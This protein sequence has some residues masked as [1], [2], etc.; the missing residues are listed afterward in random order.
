MRNGSRYL[1]SEAIEISKGSSASLG[2]EA[3]AHFVGSQGTE[4][5]LMAAI[6]IGILVGEFRAAVICALCWMR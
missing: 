6:P 5:R 3:R 4:E 1:R 2:M